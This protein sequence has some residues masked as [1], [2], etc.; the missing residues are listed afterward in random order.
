SLPRYISDSNGD[1]RRAE[2]NKVIVVAAD[3]TRGLANGLNLDARHRRQSTRKKLVLHFASD[4]YL[5][6]Q[7]PA[8][9]FHFDELADGAG[10]PVERFAQLAQ[11][12]AALNA[13]MVCQVARLHVLGR[14]IEFG[15]GPRDGARHHYSGDERNTL[16][17]EQQH[18][19]SKESNEVQ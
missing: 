18:R 16:D 7:A 9:V 8:L 14:A 1:M 3:G 17:Q 15:D 6:L 5:V 19:Q 10:H 12:V 4:G 11:L 2:L 13:H